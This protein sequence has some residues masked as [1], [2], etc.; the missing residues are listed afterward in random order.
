MNQ[1]DCEALKAS[2]KVRASEALARSQRRSARRKARQDAK[3][4]RT[5]KTE[6]AQG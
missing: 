3:Y 1:T 5:K 6:Q 2:D 4:G